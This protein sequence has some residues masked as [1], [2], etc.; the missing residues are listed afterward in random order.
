MD[1]I[2][3]LTSLLVRTANNLDFVGFER[4]LIVKL[5]R[6]IFQKEGPNIVTEAIGVQTALG[7]FQSRSGELPENLP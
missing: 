1:R 3:C 6:N 7:G 5:E 2:S 4:T